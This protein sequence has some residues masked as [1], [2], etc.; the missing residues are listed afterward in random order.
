MN[1]EHLYLYNIAEPIPPLKYN[2]ETFKP[3]FITTNPFSNGFSKNPYLLC[4]PTS[5][6][7]HESKSHPWIDKTVKQLKENGNK[8][9]EA[10]NYMQA[11]SLYSQA[12]NYNPYT[13]VLYSNRAAGFLSKFNG[14]PTYLNK[15]FKKE[16]KVCVI[17]ILS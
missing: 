1:P 9:Y 15:V 6:I 10:K 13:T 12:L 3:N 16:L 14:F 8:A 2:T 4:T 11:I 17:L 5:S 7:M